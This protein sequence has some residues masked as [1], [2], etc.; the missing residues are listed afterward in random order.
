[1]KVRPYLICITALALFFP[2]V[3]AASERATPLPT[4][5][6]EILRDYLEGDELGLQR[7]EKGTKIPLNSLI[8]TTE[9]GD[10]RDNSVVLSFDRVDITDDFLHDLFIAGRSEIREKHPFSFSNVQ[11]ILTKGKFYLYIGAGIILHLREE[12]PMLQGYRTFRGSDIRATVELVTGE[13]FVSFD[14]KIIKRRLAS[15]SVV[16][17]GNVVR[18]TK[19]PSRISENVLL[20]DVRLVLPQDY[21]PVSLDPGISGKRD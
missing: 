21:P 9:T 20:D 10:A 12:D 6:N 2:V 18:G 8:V 11:P 7:L 14:H 1:M 4:N 13:A 17:Y 19:H 15:F 3:A 5:P 16:W